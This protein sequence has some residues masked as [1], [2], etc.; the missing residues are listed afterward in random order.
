MSRD[1]TDHQK[2]S[3][4]CPSQAPFLPS[5]LPFLPSSFALF[6]RLALDPA[7]ASRPRGAAA[8][9]QARPSTFSPLWRLDAGQHKLLPFLLQTA[10]A[11]C[12]PPVSPFVNVAHCSEE[13][14]RDS[15]ST[16]G[17][18]RWQ[19]SSRVAACGPRRGARLGKRGPASR[20]TVARVGQP[21]PLLP[22]Q[23]AICSK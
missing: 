10:S 15:P 8:P 22:G 1:K 3:F 5:F 23:P 7:L 6:V 19:A 4:L 13:T 11:R 12:V 21:L 14:P 18:V 17:R 20:W 16:D 9:L 2:G